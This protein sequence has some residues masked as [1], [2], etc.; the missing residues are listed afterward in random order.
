MLRRTTRWIRDNPL[1]SLVLFGVCLAIWPF[2]YV[3]FITHAYMWLRSGGPGNGFAMRVIG[4]QYYWLSTGGLAVIA[5]YCALTGATI[6]LT[7]L[8]LYP[9]L[10]RHVR[11]NRNDSYR[12]R[13]ASPTA[14]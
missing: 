1:A 5:V 7:V 11:A 6:A 3:V 13:N 4:I 8:V 2:S 10:R 9:M 12:S 14:L